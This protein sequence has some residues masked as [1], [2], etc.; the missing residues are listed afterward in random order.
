MLIV[1]IPNDLG[2]LYF[3]LNE[4]KKFFLQICKDI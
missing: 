2:F 4:K 3:R 1:F